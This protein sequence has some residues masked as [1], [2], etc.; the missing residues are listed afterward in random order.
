MIFG[1]DFSSILND[2]ID[3]FC[4][5]NN[6]II[7]K[8][9]IKIEFKNYSIDMD[10]TILLDNIINEK[11]IITITRWFRTNKNESLGFG[12]YKI[13]LDEGLFIFQLQDSNN[14]SAI[15]TGFLMEDTFETRL[16]IASITEETIIQKCQ[17]ILKII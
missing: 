1:K 6:T 2:F 12:I 15:L 5:Q 9:K 16:L 17:D 7:N 8:K 14:G 11:S 10:N 3:K 4:N 13:D